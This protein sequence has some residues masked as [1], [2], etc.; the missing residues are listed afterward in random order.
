MVGY[1]RESIN[2]DVTVRYRKAPALV[3]SGMCLSRS[4]KMTD[5][6]F[7]NSRD[8]LGPT[9]SP[10]QQRAIHEL[11][12]LE[13]DDFWLAAAHRNGVYDRDKEILYAA[14]MNRKVPAREFPPILMS[15]ELKWDR[16]YFDPFMF[17]LLK[18][19]P[20]IIVMIIMMRLLGKWLKRRRQKR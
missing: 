8:I 19:I 14:E 11:E 5:L 9:V 7:T 1:G 17:I 6:E 3:I 13:W 18:V 2:D 20:S 4:C 10:R 16:T 15:A 12:K